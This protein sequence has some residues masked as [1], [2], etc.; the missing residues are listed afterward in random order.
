MARFSISLT[1]PAHIDWIN[2]HH[3]PSKAV[4]LLIE[5]QLNQPASKANVDLGAIRAVM[6]TVLEERLAGLSV[7]GQTATQPT[8]ID[9]LGAFDDMAE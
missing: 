7:T 9:P 5:R 1:D 3:S 8:D 4:Q 2:S 6:E